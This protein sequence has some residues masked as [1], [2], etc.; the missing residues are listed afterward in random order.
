MESYPQGLLSTPFAETQPFPPVVSLML[1]RLAT[2]LD[3]TLER[4]LQTS[5]ARPL[6]WNAVVVGRQSVSR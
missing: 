1:S 3:P 4:I 2:R 6:A 5:P